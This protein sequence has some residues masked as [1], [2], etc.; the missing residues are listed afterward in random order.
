MIPLFPF[1]RMIRNYGINTRVFLSNTN[2]L[3]NTFLQEIDLIVC[4]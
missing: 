3:D 2:E 4:L 1:L